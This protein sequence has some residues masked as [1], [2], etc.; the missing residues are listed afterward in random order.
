MECR[1]GAQ[2]SGLFQTEKLFIGIHGFD[3]W[4][5]GLIHIHTDVHV[6]V[7]VTLHVHGIM[8][9]YTHQYMYIYI[10]VYIYMYIFVCMHAYR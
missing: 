7:S 10:H 2:Q 6:C 3:C 4:H 9:G 1:K 8:Q 5:I